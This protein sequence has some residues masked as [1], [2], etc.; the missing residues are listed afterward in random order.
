MQQVPVAG[1]PVEFL[2]EEHQDFILVITDWR[3]VALVAG[4]IV[5]AVVSFLWWRHRHRRTIN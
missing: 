2:P 1:R 4:A 5:L 3:A